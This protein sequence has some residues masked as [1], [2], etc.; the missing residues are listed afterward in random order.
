[1]QSFNPSAVITITSE[2]SEPFLRPEPIA[3]IVEAM[4]CQR[5]KAAPDAS[6]RRTR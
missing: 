4:V 1:M 6:S 3:M 2:R 5:S